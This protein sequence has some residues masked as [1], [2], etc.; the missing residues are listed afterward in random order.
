MY[1]S[2]IIHKF[3][4]P[5]L[6]QYILKFHCAH[7]NYIEPNSTVPKLYTLKLRRCKAPLASMLAQALCILCSLPHVTPFF[8]HMSHYFFPNFWPPPSPHS[9]GVLWHHLW[10]A[11]QIEMLFM[12][13]F[14]NPIGHSLEYCFSNYVRTTIN[15]RLAVQRETIWQV[16]LKICP[17]GLWSF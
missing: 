3:R 6:P 15:F 8:T 2:G 5:S 10:M 4:P 9:P 14:S 11:P 1:I 7:P 16:C 12:E 13:N 17:V